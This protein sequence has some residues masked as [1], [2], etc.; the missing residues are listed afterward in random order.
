MLL[1][2]YLEGHILQSAVINLNIIYISY[3]NFVFLPL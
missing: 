1:L 3:E 2:Q